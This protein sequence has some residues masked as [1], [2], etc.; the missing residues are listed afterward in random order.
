MLPLPSE[1]EGWGEWDLQVKYFMLRRQP[2]TTKK[3]RAK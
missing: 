2:W 1:G 3:N